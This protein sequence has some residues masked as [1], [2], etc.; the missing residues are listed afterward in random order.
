MNVNTWVA[1]ATECRSTLGREQS[2]FKKYGGHE[3]RVNCALNRESVSIK[4]LVMRADVT[5]PVKMFWK[6]KLESEFITESFP[7]A[8][9][10]VCKRLKIREAVHDCVLYT[11]RNAAADA[12]S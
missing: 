2:V 1:C 11:E 8:L 7:L 10:S 9:S 6:S 3:T 4:E 12:D 5:V